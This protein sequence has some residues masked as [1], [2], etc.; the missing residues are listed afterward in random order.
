MTISISKQQF[1]WFTPR[2]AILP[3]LFHPYFPA[4]RQLSDCAIQGPF[5]SCLMPSNKME[6]NR[7]VHREAITL[8]VTLKLK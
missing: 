7:A 4:P 1:R 6:V 8:F 2:P 3:E 5:P